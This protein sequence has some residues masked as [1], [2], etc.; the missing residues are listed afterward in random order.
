MRGEVG[1]S[2][3]H[4]LHARAGC[5]D[6]LE[7]DHSLGGLEDRVDQN[8]PLEAGLGLQLG[9]QTVH[10]VDVPG[11]LDLGDHHDLELVADLGDQRGQVVEHPGALQGVDPGPERGLAE[12]GLL[13][14]ADQALPRSLLAVDRNR[15]L[16]VAEQD[17][18]LGCDIGR[19]GD[20]LLVG[21]VQEVDHP[22]GL[23]GDLTQRLGGADR[24]RLEEVSGVSHAAP[25]VVRPLSVAT[26]T[27]R[28]FV[29]GGG[30][31]RRP[32]YLESM[33]GAASDS[34]QDWLLPESTRPPLI[35]ELERRIEEALATAR[36]SEAA[37]MT[38]GAAAL[39]AAEQARRAA[40]LA[41]RASIAASDAQQVVASVAVASPPAAPVQ[42]QPADK[43]LGDFSE[44]ADR[45]VARLRQLQR[46]PLAAPSASDAAGQ[47]QSA[48]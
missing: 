31:R 48:S 15:V 26:L 21:E 39:A 3:A 12:V 16:E 17:V 4:P 19:L 30:V 24:L 28:A 43:G 6:L 23:D 42:P 5:G 37:V 38:V 10:V 32:P 1:R 8:W 47:P 2:E 20:H 7:V 14:G 44:R 9:Q 33:E 29:A 22:R 11:A 25:R 45:L 46:V 18:C 35:G 13:G 27:K 41:E 34:T 36:A 40:E